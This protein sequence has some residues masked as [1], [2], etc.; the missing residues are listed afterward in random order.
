MP[1]ASDYEI[2]LCNALRA[3]FL[4]ELKREQPRVDVILTVMKGLE[5]SECSIGYVKRG[6]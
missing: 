4:E 3:I 6:F 1:K 5:T 2:P